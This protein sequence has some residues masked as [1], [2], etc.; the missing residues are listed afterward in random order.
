MTTDERDA[1]PE[2]AVPSSMSI[3][4]RKASRLYLIVAALALVAM[5][6]ETL[7]GHPGAGSIFAAILSAPWSMLVAKFLPPLPGDWP[8]AAGLAIRMVPLAL[9]MLLNA[10]IVAGIA[11]RSERDVRG[12][13]SR[14]SLLLFCALGLPAL[15]GCILTSRQVVLVAAPVS[16]TQIY[17][18]GRLWTFYAF[19]LA[20]SPA[21]AEH[22]GK[23]RAASELTLM[24]AFTN[25]ATIIS[26]PNPAV[27][28][29]IGGVPDTTPVFA[30]GTEL[31]GP[32]NLAYL[33]TRRL[34]W[35]AGAKLFTHPG[36]LQAEIVGDGRFG[37]IVASV[38]PTPAFGGAEIHDFH[39]GAVLEVK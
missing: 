16:E 25:P 11:A 12:V 38:F 22:R 30:T 19:D 33:E 27:D 29:V 9:F 39:L 7:L 2:A 31:W 23:I 1:A 8:L 35:N 28:V 32:L 10:A 4:G 24:G 26:P 15:S 3:W 5:L 14:A 6:V 13:A 17:N 37:I 21:W 20:A 34:D 36:P 18:N